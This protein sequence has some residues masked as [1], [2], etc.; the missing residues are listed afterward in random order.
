[1]FN[2]VLVGV[3]T[4]SGGRDAVA[5]ARQL[6]SPDGKLTLV[7]VDDAGAA[8]FERNLRFGY[9][10]AGHE[11]T[12][13]LLEQERRAAGVDAG[14]LRV[15]AASVGEGLHRLAQA[16][17]ADLLV[18]G[19][20]SRGRLG[21]A[22]LGDDTRDSLNGASCAVAVAPAG[23]AELERELAVIGVAFDGK[24]DSIAALAA[25]RELAAQSG[26]ALQACE[27]VSLPGY[28][29]SSAFVV[30][31]AESIEASVAAAGARLSELDGVDARAVYGVAGEELASFSRD[32]DLMIVGSRGYGP[33]RRLIYGSTANYLLGHAGCALLVLARSAGPPTGEATGRAGE[34]A[35]GET[36]PPAVGATR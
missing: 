16:H 22:L 2:D 30:A 19:S 24:P 11:A 29:Y 32:V 1:M 31:W 36:S 33:A 17:A 25:A 6:V 9:D 12:A 15:S 13:R 20:C 27:V 28:A 35:D 26:A 3:D 14:L 5:L 7:H 34:V 8:I 18:L 4:R 23:Y 10:A 21:R